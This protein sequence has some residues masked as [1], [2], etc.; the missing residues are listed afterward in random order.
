MLTPEQIE[1]QRDRVYRRLSTR[2]V[3]SMDDAAQFI[4]A[5]GFCLL[6][7]STLAIELPSLFEAVKGRRDAHIEDW[8]ADSDR[9]WVWKNDLPATKRAYYG[10]AL[11]SGKPVFVSLKWLPYLIACK[12][13]EDMNREYER[14]RVS[15]DARRTYTALQVGGPMPTMALRAAA[16]L[17]RPGDN[18]RYHRALDELQRALVVMPI[19][20]TRETGNWTSQIFDLVARWF[21]AETARARQIDVD[22]ARRALVRRYVQTVLAAKPAMIARV[23]GWSRE[24]TQIV[25]DDMLARRIVRERE[26]WI[27]LNG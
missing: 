26:D 2:R 27:V 25:I 14:G 1:R 13:P 9:V 6:F 20:A 18:N 23:M 24:Q 8:D 10:K 21:P 3:R 5:V 7:A 12:A 11:A 22:T 16:G 17:D 15:L 4:D 19:G